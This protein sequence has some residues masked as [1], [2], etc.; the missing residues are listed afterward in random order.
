MMR[1]LGPLAVLATLAS[2]SLARGVEAQGGRAGRGRGDVPP[3]A[4]P[5]GG[6]RMDPEE[7]ALRRQIRQRFNERVKRQLSLSDDQARQLEQTDQKFNRQRADVTRDERDARQGLRALLD[8]STATPDATK[9][10]QFLQRL[11]QAQRKRA[12]LLEEEQK[13]LAGFLN[14]VQRAKFLGLREQLR[15]TVNA[16]QQGGGRRGAPPPPD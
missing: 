10:D 2:L 8:D 15:Q 13:E 1:G 4:M 12:D 7:Q 6:G 14:P 5:P 9:V 11:V 3:G 16:L